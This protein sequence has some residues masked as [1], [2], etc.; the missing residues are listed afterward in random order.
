MPVII[1]KERDVI[2]VSA[3]DAT[4]RMRWLSNREFQ[5]IYMKHSEMRALPELPEGEEP[6]VPEGEEQK[7]EV[8]LINAIDWVYDLCGNAIIG[9][10]GVKDEDGNDVPFNRELIGELPPGVISDIAQQYVDKRQ[11]KVVVKEKKKRAVRKN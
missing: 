8:Q 9:W 6:K 10:S 5:A 11:A 7:F 1:K 2:T 3:E 4:F